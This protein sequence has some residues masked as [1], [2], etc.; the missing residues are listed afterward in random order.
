MRT[1]L[2]VDDDPLARLHLER[3]LMREGYSVV[4]ATNGQEGVM[5][6]HKKAPDVI[7][8]DV[9]MPVMNGHEATRRIRAETPSGAV[10]PPVIFLTGVDDHELLAECLRCGGD[11]FISKPFNHIILRARLNAWLRRVELAEKIAM[12]REAIEKVILKMR[13]DDRFNPIGMRVFM[14]P[15]E[16][17]TGDL[18][19]AACDAEGI[20]YVLLGDF[21]GHGLSAAVCGPMVSEI[22]YSMIQNG[23]SSRDIL[24]KIN[25]KIHQRLPVD[26]FLT[27]CFI[28]LDRRIGR[29]TIYNAG[30]HPLF[31]YRNDTVIEGPL[32]THTPLGILKNVVFDQVESF[33][34]V[35]PNDLIYLHSDGI[36]ETQSP[37]GTF[38]GTNNLLTVLSGI[39]LSGQPLE[40]IQEALEL[41]RGNTL[42]RDDI[43]LV[44]LKV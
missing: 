10:M 15:V 13:Q 43:T 19:L 11:D 23:V 26:M 14:T 36:Y 9:M 30:M 35:Q 5:Q 38:F 31:L 33:L 41:F 7:L 28:V 18:V 2:I 29:M 6:F 21:T 39:A 12:D 27:A 24:T 4:V 20:Q 37:N 42:Q 32:S 3:F 44:E 22:F 34:D 40:A 25:D 8:M 17:T 1:I 16:N